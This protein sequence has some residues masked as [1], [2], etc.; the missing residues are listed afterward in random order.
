[1][2]RY[3][4]MGDHVTRYAKAVDVNHAAIRTALRRF[5][6]VLDMSKAGQGVPDLLARHVMTGAA[7]WLEVK[8]PVGKRKPKAAPLTPAQLE[9][10]EWLHVEVV[11]NVVDAARAVGIRWEEP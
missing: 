5:T 11:T 9:L 2:R 3:L 1:M 7:I 8:R 6:Q 4:G 10:R